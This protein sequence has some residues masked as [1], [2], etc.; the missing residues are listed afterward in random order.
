MPRGPRT[1]NKSIETLLSEV[2]Q[3]IAYH[4]SHLNAL[5]AKRKSLMET[6]EKA[7]LDALYKALKRSGKSPS[8]WISEL[9]D[10]AI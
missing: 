3:K 5:N 1:P 10:K 7:E 2:D 9:S 6:R 8:E 4:Q